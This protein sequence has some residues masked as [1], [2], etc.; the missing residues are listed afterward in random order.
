MIDSSLLPFWR[1]VSQIQ[2]WAES[3]Q[4]EENRAQSADYLKAFS[5]PPD[6]LIVVVKMK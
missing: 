4:S 1:I 2:I 5:R 3:L 6:L